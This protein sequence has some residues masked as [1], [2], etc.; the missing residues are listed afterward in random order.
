MAELARVGV[1]LDGE[2]LAAFDEF[3]HARG[4]ENR[5]EAIR[6]LI[7][8]ALNEDQWGEGEIC[9][10]TLTLVYDHH[11]NDLAKRLVALQHEY[12]DAIIATMHVHLDH[13]N[14]LECLVLKGAPTLVRDLAQKLIATRGVKYGVFNRAPNGADLA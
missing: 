10:G 12:H 8:N 11:R 2:L 5:S 13:H 6:D 1:S 4:Y 7:R 3:C 9:G 14:C